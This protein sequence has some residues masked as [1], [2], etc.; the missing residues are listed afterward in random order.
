MIPETFREKIMAYI[1]AVVLKDDTEKKLQ[2]SL[3]KT[4]DDQMKGRAEILPFTK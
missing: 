1:N 3:C 4:P 2:N